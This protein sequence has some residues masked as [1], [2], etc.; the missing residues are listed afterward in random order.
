MTSIDESKR[1]R[2]HFATAV[3]ADEDKRTHCVS[4]RLNVREL[5][6][7]DEL[8]KQVNMERGEYLRTA[9]LHQLP[10]TIPAINREAWSS[11]AS[12]TAN[13][14]QIARALNMTGDVQMEEVRSALKSLRTQLINI[15]GVFDE[16][17]SGSR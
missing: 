8:R 14:N 7:L 3:L 6:Q 1:R 13:L 11:L 12:T 5:A 2:R 9:A 10:P 17:E 15:G 4:T 16:S